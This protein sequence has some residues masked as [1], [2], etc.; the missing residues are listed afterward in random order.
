V[1]PE[2]GPARSSR[3]TT[4]GAVEDVGHL[5]IR[6]SRSLRRFTQIE[7]NAGDPISGL[8]SSRREVTP[9]N[10]GLNEILRRAR[11]SWDLPVTGGTS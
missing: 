10:G 11:V 6:K 4:A 1:Q 5:L 9:L 8:L 2:F 3:R 7:R